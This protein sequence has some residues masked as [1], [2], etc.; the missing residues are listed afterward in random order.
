MWFWFAATA[1]T[2]SVVPR[3]VHAQSARDL[4]SPVGD[5]SATTGG[6][7]PST[8]PP[9]QPPSS[10]ESVDVPPPP[11]SAQPGIQY[12]GQPDARRRAPLTT[13]AGVRIPSGIATRLRALDSDFQV[14]A[15]RGGGSIVDG[16]LGILTGGLTITIGIL[17]L[18][19]PAGPGGL[20][21]SPYL[22]TYGGASAVR[23]ILSLVLMTN[24]SGA[25]ITYSHMPMTTMAEVQ[26]RLDYGERELAS[27]ADRARL[28]RIIDGSLNVAVGLAIIPIYLGPNNFEIRN[29]FDWFVLIGAGISAISGVITLLS[30]TE[31]ERRWS[32]YE[33]LRDRLRA[34]GEGGDARTGDDAPRSELELEVPAGRGPSIAPMASGGAGSGVVGVTGTF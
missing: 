21:M 34:R 3:G 12:P 22:F 16:V 28:S 17:L 18:E 10:Y 15:A 14:L 2:I 30:S 5:P 7:A 11:G 26:A 9:A 6:R 19:E 13:D 27:L 8:T 20:N 29:T 23:G 33:E 4:G 1:L 31:A 25:A 32:A 24:P